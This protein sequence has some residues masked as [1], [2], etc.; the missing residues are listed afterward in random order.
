MVA[1]LQAGVNGAAIN[2]AGVVLGVGGI[3]ATWLWLRV[4]KR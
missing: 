2:A 4:L 3:A 1:P